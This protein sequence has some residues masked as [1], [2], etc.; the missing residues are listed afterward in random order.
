[1]KESC[2]GALLGAAAIPSDKSIDRFL[3]RGII[4]SAFLEIRLEK[5]NDFRALY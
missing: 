4:V 1:M 5:T 2:F 3:Q